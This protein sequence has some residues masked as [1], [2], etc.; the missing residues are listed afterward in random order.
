MISFENEEKM[1]TMLEIKFQQ[2]LDRFPTK[3]EVCTNSVRQ[4]TKY[5]AKIE[6]TL[7]RRE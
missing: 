2:A 3:T 4:K 6:K 7:K 1:L 5:K